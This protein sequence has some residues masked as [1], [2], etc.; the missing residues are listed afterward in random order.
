[1]KD[2]WKVWDDDK[3]YGELFY[4]RAVG[5]LSEMESS[6]AVAKH[7][8][9]LVCK[10]DTILDVGCGSGHYLVSLDKAINVPFLYHGVDSTEYY[11]EMGQK[12]FSGGDNKNSQRISCKFEVGDIFHLHIEDNYAD[13]TM[14]NNVLLHLPSIKK[15]LCELWRVTKK[16]LVLR[17]LIGSVSFRI[18]QVNNPEEYTPEGEPM[19]FHFFNIYS[20]NYIKTLIRDLPWV[21]TF[22]FIEDRDFNPE[23]IELS[24]YKGDYKPH[25]LTTIV[26]G[27]QVNN[28]ILQPWQFLIVEKG[29]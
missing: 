23:N 16:F 26:S 12:A 29:E 2:N 14:C 15:P 7:I 27:M 13:I 6:K 21:K 4:N 19:N 20:K 10:D 11:I 25:D 17:T 28:Y 24:N 18:K 22:R 9:K 5:N 3:R 1:M 8:A